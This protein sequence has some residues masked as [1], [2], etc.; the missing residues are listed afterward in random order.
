[1]SEIE[2]YGIPEKWANGNIVVSFLGSCKDKGRVIITSKSEYPDGR[3]QYGAWP[4]DDFD[5]AM[6]NENAIE[7]VA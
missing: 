2:T 7:E 6:A 1:M 5:I 3:V 4:L